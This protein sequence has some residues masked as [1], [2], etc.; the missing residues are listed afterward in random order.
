MWVSAFT[1]TISKFAYVSNFTYVSKYVHVNGALAGYK[2]DILPQKSPLYRFEIAF[3]G[4]WTFQTVTWYPC[5]IQVFIAFD[6]LYELDT[7]KIGLPKII[8]NL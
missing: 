8:L 7:K 5:Y 3:T 1:C 4:I 6:Y 2:I